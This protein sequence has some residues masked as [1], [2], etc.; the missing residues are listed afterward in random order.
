MAPLTAGIVDEVE[1]RIREPLQTYP[2]MG[3]T[4]IAELRPPSVVDFVVHV[5]TWR[6]AFIAVTHGPRVSGACTLLDR[7]ARI[8]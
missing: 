4:A 7:P 1:P 6:C 5:S 8:R 2:R 3:V